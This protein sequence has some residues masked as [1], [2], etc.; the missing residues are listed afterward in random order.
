MLS[1]IKFKDARNTKKNETCS[2]FLFLMNCFLGCN[3]R[4][5][6]FFGTVGFIFPFV[7]SVIPSEIE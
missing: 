4:A 1:Y 2:K 6:N 3:V 7:S 5:V